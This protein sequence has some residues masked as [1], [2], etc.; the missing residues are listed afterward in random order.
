MFCVFYRI[1]IEDSNVKMFVQQLTV[2]DSM[3]CGVNNDGNSKKVYF[4]R[5]GSTVTLNRNTVSHVS[6][7]NGL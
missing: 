4:T 7:S 6:L 3:G 1:F 5:N 2:G